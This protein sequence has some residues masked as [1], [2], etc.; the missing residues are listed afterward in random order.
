M[1]R[2]LI[3]GCGCRGLQLTRALREAGHAVRGTTRDP[4]RRAEIEAAGAEPFVGDPNLVG[5]L[6]P[7]L[8]HV[9]VACILLG[10]AT[11]TEEALT[12]LHGTRL[13]MLLERM[14]DTTVR[15]VVYQAAGSLDAA[16]LR[17]GAE[18]VRHACER[19][20]IPYEPLTTDPAS[21]DAWIADTVTAIERA[22][23]GRD[24]YAS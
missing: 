19:S 18:R 15:G 23:V 22:L 24:Q 17:G 14:L 11:G 6:A 8:A 12:A 13:D 3:V 10:S 2:C 5:T 20:L 4:G 21:G 7:A 9:G 16:L 1:A